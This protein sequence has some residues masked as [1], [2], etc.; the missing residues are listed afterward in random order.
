MGQ[1]KVL[2]EYKDYVNI[3]EYVY[4]KD[5]LGYV[6]PERQKVTHDG[7]EIVFNYK[8]IDYKITYDLDG[9]EFG[10]NALVKD[11]YTIEQEYTPPV[12]TKVGYVFDS[13][14]PKSINRGSIGLV[15]FRAN[16]TLAPILLPGRE[17]NAKFKEL[18]G[19]EENWKKLIAFQV[20]ET[21]PK[22]SD[23]AVD[24]SSTDTSAYAWYVADAKCIML[25]SEYEVTYNQ[26]SA[27]AFEGFESLRDINDLVAIHM[28][29]GTDVSEMFNGCKVLTNVTVLEQ[30]AGVQFSKMDNIFEGT[31]AYDVNTTPTWYKY[32]VDVQVVSSTG[33]AIDTYTTRVT[34]GKIFYAKKYP[35]YT[36]AEDDK[37][38]V[39]TENCTK[40]IRVEPINYSITYVFSDGIFKPEKKTFTVEEEFTPKPI[41]NNRPRFIGWTPEKINN[42]TVGD[43]MFIARYG[44]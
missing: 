3:D 14:Y 2:N 17:L 35:G 39:V 21:K 4:P 19:S 8:P 34:P 9:G 28:N 42:G 40:I 30:F 29:N 20:S 24:I 5:I 32:S 23:K 12:P 36:I 13:W 6:T 33:A 1:E 43:V 7:Q 15:N 44:E 38:F 31:M 25:Y 11:T 18:C 26:D 16:W 41:M 10:E 37:S 27:G 22:K